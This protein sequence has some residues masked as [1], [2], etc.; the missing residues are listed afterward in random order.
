M[1]N[2]QTPTSI[3]PSSCSGARR[4]RAPGNLRLCLPSLHSGA[5]HPWPTPPAPG[6]GGSPLSEAAAGKLPM[7][8][9]TDRRGQ[10]SHKLLRL[11]FHLQVAVTSLNPVPLPPPLTHSPPHTSRHQPLLPSA[12]AKRQPRHVVG[13]Q[14]RQVTPWRCHPHPCWQVQTPTLAQSRAWTTCPPKAC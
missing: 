13:D 10:S 1:R 7:K 2:L 6:C 11:L 8:G 4:T 12:L 5:E 14:G 3:F 9:Q